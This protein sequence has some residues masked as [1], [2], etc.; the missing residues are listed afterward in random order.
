MEKR[1]NKRQ[2]NRKRKDPENIENRMGNRFKIATV[3]FF[4]LLGVVAFRL[5]WIIAFNGEK[6]TKAALAQ[7][8]STTTVL[9]AKRGDIVD[10][11]GVQFA[12]STKV[13]NLILDPRVILSDA[14]RYLDPTTSL[15]EK[16]YGIPK[17]ELTLTITDNPESSYVVLKRNLTFGEVE[18]FQEECNSGSN[19][20]GVWL[21]DSYKRNYT[22]NTLAASVIGFLQDGK[23]IYGLELQYD[24]ELSGSDGMTYSFVNGDNVLETVRNDA[25]DGNTLKLTIDY[26]IQSIV[27]TQL[28][29]T[30]QQTN[31][32]TV[33]VIVQNPQNGE[34]L[35]M[36]DSGSFDLNNPR[37]LSIMYTQEQINAMSDAD[38]I[39]ALSEVWKNF[40]VTQSYEPG[41]TFKPF[42]VAMALEENKVSESDQYECYG[43]QTFFEGTEWQQTI[44][45][46]D[47][48]GHGVLDLK[49]AVRESC[50]M[51][52][53]Q[54][55]EKLGKE[56]FCKYQ[57]KFGFGQYTGIDLPN[58][59]S[60]QGL[61]YSV[62]NMTELD[63]ATNSF[64]QNFNLTMIQMTSAF[65]SLINGGYYYKPYVV[66]G[67]YNENNE[68]VKSNDKEL[69]SRTISADTQEFIKE[70]LRSV[71]AEGTG[72]AAAVSGYKIA[73]KTGTAQ[74]YDKT[75]ELYVI[76]FLG[77]APYDDPEVVCYVVIDEPETG[78][79]SF[80]GADLFSRIMT[81]VLSYLNVQPDDN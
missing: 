26:N 44:W 23:G 56:L 19:I 12:T 77:F 13:Y 50:N 73:G 18:D 43:S 74:K 28:A 72:S 3:V 35:A 17:S 29:L 9:T 10:R 65:S 25:I 47:R 15:I 54:I 5:V 52:L 62:E 24:D 21:E 79:A 20:A 61:L 81:E 2:N 38:T 53:S 57:E 71:V 6:Y 7:T 70:S 46:H 80:F 78:S 41:S 68:L 51:A 27:E 36:A 30:K 49:G 63:L 11:N 8:E 16:Y 37:D 67:I 75:E 14:E 1:N 33:A 55:G 4:V 66:K 32:K 42:T 69:V 59:M 76:S 48:A 22:Y 31:A 60:C 40:C 39:D 34:I 45:C 58:E 64:G